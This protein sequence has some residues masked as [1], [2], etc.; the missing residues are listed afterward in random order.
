[1]MVCVL[2]NSCWV[3]DLIK[4]YCTEEP[5]PYQLPYEEY[6]SNPS[7]R[8]MIDIVYQQELRPSIPVRYYEIPVSAR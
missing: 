3:V 6:V 1:M 8:E 4:D 7:V 5:E 2:N